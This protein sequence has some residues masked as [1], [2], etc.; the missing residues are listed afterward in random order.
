MA[1]SHLEGLPS[2][3]F[4]IVDTPLSAQNLDQ[5]IKPLVLFSLQTN[6][7]SPLGIQEIFVTVRCILGRDELRIVTNHVRNQIKSRPVA[8]RVLE[9]F[10]VSSTLFRDVF[11][12]QAGI[13][14]LINLD[15]AGLKNIGVVD[16][17]PM[18][19]QKPGLHSLATG[20]KHFSL[21]EGILLGKFL[22]ILT[23]FFYVHSG[24]QNQSALSFCSFENLLAIR[25]G[26]NGKRTKP[27]HNPQQQAEIPAD[28]S[29]HCCSRRHI[30]LLALE[31][32]F[33]RITTAML[34]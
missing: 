32:S 14:E 10:W 12:Q 27:K 6:L 28:Y 19:D 7:V 34:L 18:L 23:R 24:I 4:H 8:Q 13:F 11:R 33:Q 29:P 25:G 22:R 2:E 17:G 16:I 1:F 21:N 9:A 20:T 15:D 5:M 26:P 31:R 3:P 30:L